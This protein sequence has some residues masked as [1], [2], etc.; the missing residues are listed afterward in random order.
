ML[1]VN[2]WLLVRFIRAKKRKLVDDY[3]I[4]NIHLQPSTWSS[5]SLNFAVFE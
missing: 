3:I 1:V 2:E 4:G 5:A